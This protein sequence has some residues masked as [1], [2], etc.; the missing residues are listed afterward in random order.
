MKEKKHEVN[1]SK[2][3]NSP[4]SRVILRTQHVNEQQRGRWRLDDHLCNSLRFEPSY[5]SSILYNHDDINAAQFSDV[6][7]GKEVA[8]YSAIRPITI[9]DIVQAVIHLVAARL[10]WVD[11]R[12][13]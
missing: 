12:P 8:S 9:D 6:E 5:I 7:P 13:L 10:R 1:M 11:G 2:P 4:V 3:R